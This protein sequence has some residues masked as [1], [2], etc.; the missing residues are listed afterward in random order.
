M[1]RELTFRLGFLMQVWG[2]LGALPFRKRR[3]EDGEGERRRWEGLI[4][5][6]RWRYM[7]F[8]RT[9]PLI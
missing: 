7:C 3:A 6:F 8:C 1:F 5:S 4:S 9:Y 2:V